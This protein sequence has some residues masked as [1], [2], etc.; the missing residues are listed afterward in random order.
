MIKIKVV[1]E[2]QKDILGKEC[3]TNINE[4]SAELAV[5]LLAYY[6]RS[7]VKPLSNGED[8][9]LQEFSACISK[10][11]D[12]LEANNYGLSHIV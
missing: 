12:R 1:L 2:G 4:D 3:T 10:E 11:I 6:L 8:E 5:V 7:R 9:G